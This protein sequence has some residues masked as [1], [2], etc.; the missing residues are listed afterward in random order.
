MARMAR[1]LLWEGDKTINP[2]EFVVISQTYAI[3]FLASLISSNDIVSV[4]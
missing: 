3:A 4:W 2:D 1:D